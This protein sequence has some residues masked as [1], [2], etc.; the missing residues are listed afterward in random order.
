MYGEHVGD[1]QCM[2]MSQ[3]RVRSFFKLFP[4]RHVWSSLRLSTS[5]LWDTHKYILRYTQVHLYVYKCVRV[6]MYARACTHVRVVANVCPISI[7]LY[8][9]INIH[10]C[11]NS[12][13]YTIYLHTYI[14]I[15]ICMNS[16]IYIHM[17]IPGMG[18][19]VCIHVV[20]TSIVLVLPAGSPCIQAMSSSI[21]H[22]LRRPYRRL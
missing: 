19:W 18:V 16:Y 15:H 22:S 1:H 8:T 21:A 12:Y 7:Y 13:I 17:Y 9:Y 6:L 20:L 2:Y 14:N 10:T 3:A 11:I 4:L 5:G